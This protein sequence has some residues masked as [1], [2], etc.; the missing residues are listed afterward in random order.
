MMH[1]FE[2]GGPASQQRPATAMARFA[3]PMRVY[4]SSF[5]NML[6]ST[7]RSAPRFVMGTAK[8]GTDFGS[9]DTPGPYFVPIS[10]QFASPVATIG[11]ETRD[12]ALL[13]KG[14]LSFPG[15]GTYR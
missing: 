13:N 7:R 9:S 3:E 10:A 5:G 6:S 1:E 15:P 14:A 8:R 4:A 11:S 12:G 2:G